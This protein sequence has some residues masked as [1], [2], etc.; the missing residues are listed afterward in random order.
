MAKNL[1][2]TFSK[3]VDEISEFLNQ[4]IGKKRKILII[5]H[6]DDDGLC[7]GATIYNFLMEIDVAKDRIVSVCTDYSEGT[8]MKKVLEKGDIFDMIFIVDIS[9]KLDTIY[10]LKL[11]SEMS[12]SIVVWLDHHTSSANVVEA[13]YKDPTIF[14]DYNKKIIADIDE[15]RCGAL[16]AFNLFFINE[17]IPEIIRLIDDYDRWIFSFNSTEPFHYGFHNHFKLL[18]DISSSDWKD[19]IHG[20]HEN[21]HDI[22][23]IGETI[24]NDR[25]NEFK[26]IRDLS[27]FT[28]TITINGIDYVAAFINNTSGSSLL[29][30][31][32]VNNVDIA[33]KF[34]LTNELVYKYT[35]STTKDSI[36]CNEIAGYFGGGG[37]KG[38]AGF[39]STKDPI[40][41]FDIDRLS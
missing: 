13:I 3:L 39:R 4:K 35:I 32:E 24:L 30:G 29:F 11:L 21:V 9:F 19:I 7:G 2:K 31:E 26:N 6:N 20:E 28:R 12:N 15:S 5:H 37:H 1:K 10:E 18:E 41:L 40:A 22:V 38:V 8:M 23:N 34:F 36:K 17:V 14:P 16:I 27:M 33:I 25:I